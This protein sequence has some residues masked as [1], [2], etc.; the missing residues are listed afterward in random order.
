VNQPFP[1]LSELSFIQEVSLMDFFVRSPYVA[2]IIGYCNE[3]RSLLMKF[4]PGG[5]LQHWCEKNASL[6]KSNKVRVAILSDISRGIA[7]L[8]SCE[9]AHCDIKPQNVLVDQWDDRMHFVLTDFGISKILTNEYLASEAFKIR[10]I[11]GLS[12]EYAS[13]DVIR[14][15]RDRSS[16]VSAIV[17]KATD[18][19]AFSIVICFVLKLERPW[20][21]K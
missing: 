20:N 2:K 13:P 3:P 16:A 1:K 5:S 18:V 12:M 6:A 4:Y 11:R 21:S 14:R 8:H 10:N 7:A 19:Y 9:V 15:F 17:E